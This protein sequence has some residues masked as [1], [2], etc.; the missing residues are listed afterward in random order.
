MYQALKALGRETALVVYPGEFHD[1]PLHPISR[2]AC[3][4]PGLVNHYVKATPPRGNAAAG[5]GEVL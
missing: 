5:R 1:F 4:L 2:T 3:P